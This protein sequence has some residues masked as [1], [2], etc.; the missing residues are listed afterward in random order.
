MKHFSNSKLLKK[1]NFEHSQK[2]IKINIL[3]R[4]LKY[5]SPFKKN[6]IK[7]RY[8]NKGGKGCSNKLGKRYS[9]TFP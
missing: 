4:F 9:T 5:K 7:E 3:N 6:H 2:C 8:S 1:C